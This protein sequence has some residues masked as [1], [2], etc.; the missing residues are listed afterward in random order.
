MGKNLTKEEFVKNAISVHGDKYDYSDSVYI[1]SRIKLNILCKMHGIFSQ[2]PNSHLNGSGCAICKGVNKLTKEQFI[3]NAIIIHGDKYDYSKVDYINNNT[4]VKILCKIHGEFNQTPHAHKSGQGCP[5]C[6]GTFNKTLTKDEF[7]N[8]AIII[9]GDK[10]DYSKVDYINNN[11][12]VKILCKIHG[13]FEQIP[14]NH[15]K[16][17]GC[18][19][20]TGRHLC[21]K[22]EFISKSITIHGDRYDYSQVDYINNN[23]R[24]KILCKKHGLFEQTPLSHF[25]MRNGCPKCNNSKGETEIENYLKLNNIKYKPQFSFNDLVDKGELRFDFGIFEN[26][27]L[28]YLIEYNGVQHYENRKP[29]YRNEYE[30]LIAKKRDIMKIDYCNRNNIKLYIIKYDE[31]ILEKM[32]FIKI[33]N[34]YE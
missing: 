7:I 34:K 5:K 33:T 3:N 28:K 22:D 24:V 4:K 15:L 16:S 14:Y 2:L 13:E 26:N 27:N 19:K 10:Y 9:H 32:D 11:T 23:I 6:L 18:K 29:F 12:K 31:N 30:F 17:N 1:D 25:N 20:C 21:T 8:K